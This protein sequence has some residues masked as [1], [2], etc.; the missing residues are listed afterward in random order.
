MLPIHSF[1]IHLK[2]IVTF[3]TI[4]NSSIVTANQEA[5]E[6]AEIFHGERLFLETRFSQHFYQF[7]KRGGHYN[8]PIDEGDPVL[9]KTYRFFGLPPYQIPF[10]TSPFKGGSFSCRTCHMVDEHLGQKELGMRAYSDFASRSPLSKRNDKQTVTVR[11]SPILVASSIKKQDHLFHSDGEFSSLQELIIATLTQRNLGWLPHEESLASEHICNVIKNDDGSGKLANDFGNI[12]YK[13]VLSGKSS[14]GDE[15]PIEYLIDEKYRI[16]ILKSSCNEILQS[17]AN[18]LEEYIDDLQFSKDSLALSPYDTFLTINK[19]PIIPSKNE[20]DQEYSSR[21]LTL[22]NS[23]EK[24]NALKFVENNLNTENGQF[25]F[26]DQPYKFSGSELKGLKV[27]FNQTSDSKISTGNCLACHPAPHFTDFKF[28]NI[29]VTQIEY[30]AIH[31]L[32]AFNKLPIPSLAARTKNAEIY[33]PAT[34]THPN[35]QGVFR[36]AANQFDSIHTDLG[37][38]NILFNED[39][40][41]PQDKLLK[42]FCDDVNQ[43]KNKDI[44][45]QRSL[46]AFKTPTLRDLGHSAPYMH[47]GQISD[48]HAAIGF[49]L[50]TS[51]NSRNGQIRNSDKEL[52]NI[53]IEPSD[54]D[55]L[56]HFLI[57]LYEDYH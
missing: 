32:N 53:D 29:G 11:N 52:K 20:S 6:P 2:Y 27:F 9:N 28:H 38:W 47:N 18:L 19:L 43:C 30:E 14:T 4:L 55:A 37:A 54:I 21:L 48:L 39:F 22:I 15:L 56:V 10:A 7:I 49:Y 44:A 12:S 31:G 33:L 45:L 41:S 42:L 13:E 46:A 26:H 1:K 35:R 40:P 23:L 34:T 50:N 24:N 16:N 57:S 25:R 8:K 5:L 17:I 36:K 3:C 51:N